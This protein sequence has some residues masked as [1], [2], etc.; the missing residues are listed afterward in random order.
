MTLTLTLV[1][2]MSVVLGAGRLQMKG[3]EGVQIGTPTPHPPASADPPSTPWHTSTTS[4]LSLGLGIRS[5]WRGK[6]GDLRYSKYLA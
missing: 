6:S 2:T 1:W 3:H 4:G 5:R